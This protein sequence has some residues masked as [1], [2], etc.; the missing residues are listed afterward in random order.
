M[1]TKYFLNTTSGVIT[2]EYDGTDTVRVSGGDLDEPT[3][4]SRA[5]ARAMWKTL[6]RAGGTVV[7]DPER[8]IVKAALPN[9]VLAAAR[10]SLV[11]HGLIK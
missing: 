11:K 2:F 4:L 9:H 5:E 10:A 7:L 3:E 1:K 8:P 6:R